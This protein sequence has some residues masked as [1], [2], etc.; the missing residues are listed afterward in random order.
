MTATSAPSP[1]HPGLGAPGTGVRIEVGSGFE[2]LVASLPVADPEGAQRFG[3]ADRWQ[4]LAAPLP[5]EARETLLGLGAHPI[6]N[7]LGLVLETP[8]PRTAAR[9]VSHLAS[10]PRLEIVRTAIGRYRR[11][12]LRDTPA[13]VIDAAIAGSAEAQQE[14]LG[15]SWPDVEVWQLGLRF[16]L[17]APPDEMGRRVVEAFE[18]W[19]RLGFAEEETRLQEGQAR[20]REALLAENPRW[21]L[22]PLLRR[23]LPTV[24]YI[25]PPFVERVIFVPTQAI[26]PAFVFLDH[27]MEALVIF[28]VRP[29]QGGDAPPEE[30]VLIGKALGDPI[31]LRALRALAAG[32]HSLADLADELGVPRTTLAHHI[33][34]LRSAGLI[35]FTIDDGRYGRLTLRADALTRL[36]P[37]LRD[38]LGDRGPD[39]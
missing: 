32:P 6:I 18:A 29:E 11:A 8:E 34:V 28:P 13:E 31:R 7:L 35:G 30:L 26:R 24:E 17:S 15:L 16:L 20:E 23:A 27:R 9:F 37:L 36:T 33:G 1:D 19:L 5:A 39:W 2:L 21:R 25:P 4:Q 10:V 12:V 38:F 14:F 22:E 3:D